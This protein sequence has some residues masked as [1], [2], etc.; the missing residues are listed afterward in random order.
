M[1]SV[2]IRGSFSGHFKTA[3]EALQYVEKHARPFRASWEIK[4]G[5]NKTYAKG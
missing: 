5:F 1:F 4:D 2:Y 3:A